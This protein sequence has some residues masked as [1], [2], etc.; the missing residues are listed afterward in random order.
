MAVIDSIRQAGREKKLLK[1]QYRK[2]NNEIS[3]RV[4]EPY[5]IKDGRLWAYD[6]AKDDNIRQFLMVGILSAQVLE[7]VFDPRWPI[8]IA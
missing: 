4:V 6:T 8:K 1:I 5:E 2:L 7:E 3:E